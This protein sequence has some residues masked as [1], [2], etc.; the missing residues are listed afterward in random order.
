MPPLGKMS[1]NHFEHYETQKAMN[2]LI[3]DVTDPMKLFL[4][5]IF[6]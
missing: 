3:I 2:F 6:S 4:A 5:K 1:I